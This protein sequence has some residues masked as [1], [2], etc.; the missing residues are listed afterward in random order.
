MRIL[1]YEDFILGF[2]GCLLE[3]IGNIVA[4]AKVMEKYHSTFTILK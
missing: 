2:K 4:C 3:A 1:V